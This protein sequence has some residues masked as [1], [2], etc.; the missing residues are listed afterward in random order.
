MSPSAPGAP[1]AAIFGMAGHT[2]TE[3]E[4]TFFRQTRPLGYILFARNVD[5]PAQVRALV[6]DL[7]RLVADHDPLI[8]IDQEGG[9]VQ[10][11]RPPHWRFAPAMAEFGAL[12]AADPA[13]ARR[14]L[15]LNMQLIGQ[16]LA[17]LGI[18]VDCAPVMDV[19]VP[20]AHDII[21]NRAFASDPAVVADLAVAACDGLIAA[22]VVPVIKHIPG[23]GR[24][25][26]DS[27]LELPV[28]DADLA[29]LRATDFVPFAAF[30]KAGRPAFAMTAH[31]VYSAL[32]AT[33]PATTSPRIIAE[34]IRGE[35]GFDGLLMSDDLGMKALTGPFSARASAA[36]SAG[37]D[38]VLHCDGNLDDMRAVAEG[39]GDLG[40]NGMRALAAVQAV[41]RRP[42]ATV[43]AAAAEV[44]VTNALR[45]I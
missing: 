21:G 45:R 8:L 18:D 37:C 42:R 7:R 12:F 43:S 9:R 36:L 10:R 28:V 41:H 38:A 39:A 33:R 30:A 32:D 34:I 6:D 35:L 5:T 17:A 14:A 15:A 26:A 25:R 4:R 31:V 44:V 24:A 19:P 13:A 22:G 16:E 11:L 3:D 1:R 23:H 29:A 40:A 27:H 20:G 2:L